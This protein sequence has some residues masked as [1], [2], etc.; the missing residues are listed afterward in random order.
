MVNTR[1]TAILRAVAVTQE[2]KVP[3]F[4]HGVRMKAKLLQPSTIPTRNGNEHLG[5]RM[6]EALALG[7][8]AK[9]IQAYKRALKFKVPITPW[10]VAMA[11]TASIQCSA[12]G[13]LD[14]AIDI[15]KEAS[16]LGIDVKVAISRLVL[17]QMESLVSENNNPESLILETLATLQ[18]HGMEIA[19]P[20]V[21][22]LV[23]IHVDGG[24]YREALNLFDSLSSIYAISDGS[25][26]LVMLTILLRASTLLPDFRYVKWI[27]KVLSQ[28]RIVPDKRFK[29]VLVN[30]RRRARKYIDR[31]TPDAVKEEL[32]LLDKI[33]EIVNAQRS[34]LRVKRLE[35]VDKTLQIMEMAATANPS[36]EGGSESRNKIRMVKC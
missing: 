32:A 2:H 21:S 9:A 8:P 5:I 12:S 6:N 3:H 20:V 31:D 33:V 26:D 14:R 11:V 15:L 25:L 36:A 35:A 23:S 1:T 18:K 4:R 17:V 28:N 13:N 24:R 34:E 19:L 7:M 16:S 10:M 22:T 30:A 27:V 29:L